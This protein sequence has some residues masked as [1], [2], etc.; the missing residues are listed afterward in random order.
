MKMLPLRYY[1]AERFGNEEKVK[2]PV[3]FEATV[4]HATGAIDHTLVCVCVS[5][6]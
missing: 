3:V 1:Q 4:S 6:L 2:S 5:T